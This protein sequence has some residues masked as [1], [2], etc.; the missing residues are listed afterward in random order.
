MRKREKEM[1]DRMSK[2]ELSII[3]YENEKKTMYEGMKK[4]D[5]DILFIKKKYEEVNK[6]WHDENLEK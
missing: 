1:Q 2:Y 5:D 6:L 3:E 4:K